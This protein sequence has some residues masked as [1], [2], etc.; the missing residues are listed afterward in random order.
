MYEQNINKSTKIQDFA[1]YLQFIWKNAPFGQRAKD[2]LTKQK[3][4]Q[5]FL[6]RVVLVHLPIRNPDHFVRAFEI[7]ASASSN[8]S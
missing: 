7:R 3:A 5:G 8:S 2:R 6:H 1:N 4:P